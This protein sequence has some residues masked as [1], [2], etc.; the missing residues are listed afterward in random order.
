MDSVK[1]SHQIGQLA[2]SMLREVGLS[3]SPR[4]FEIWCA[5]ID[6]RSPSLSRDIQKFMHVD[7]KVT[8]EEADSL[9]QMHIARADLANNINDLASNLQLE[10]DELF[11]NIEAQGETSHQHSTE[12]GDLSQ[13]LRQSAEEYPAVGSLLEGVV[14]VTKKMREENQKLESNLA[15]STSEISTLRRNVEVI[16]KEAMSDP[17]TGVKNRKS[18]DRAIERMVEDAG[19]HLNP[20]ALIMADVDHF[21]NFNDRWGHQTGDQ[22]L[23]LVAEVMKANVKG[24]DLLARYGGEEFGI[25]LPGTTLENAHMLADRIR[26]AVESRRLKKR[27]S[28][29]DLGV[30]T[31]SMGVAVFRPDD[32]T[33]S[34]V[35]RAD[36]SLYAAKQRGRNCVIDE[37]E[38]E[39]TVQQDTKIA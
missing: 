3:A 1:N 12:L 8:Q 24:Q 21:K 23:R 16:Q 20:L 14:A 15:A 29:E 28:D 39:A 19:L 26:R 32:N 2:L 25:L 18:F 10:I 34:L 11:S 35:E 37:R 9:H 27:Q 4:N 33:Q 22:V 7:G 13:Q 36:K 38:F 5:H 17:L 30:V 6:G 31:M